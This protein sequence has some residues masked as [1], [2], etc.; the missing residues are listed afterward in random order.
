MPASAWLTQS[1]GDKVGLCLDSAD[2][3]AGSEAAGHIPGWG[4]LSIGIQWDAPWLWVFRAGI[5]GLQRTSEAMRCSQYPTVTRG[6][7]WP[8]P[9]VRVGT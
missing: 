2:K 6:S 9:W 4:F 7:G 5:T 3:A 8:F 1:F